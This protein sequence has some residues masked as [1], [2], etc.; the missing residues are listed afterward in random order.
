[1]SEINFQTQNLINGDN[2]IPGKTYFVES[3]I[4]EHG[5]KVKISGTFINYDRFNLM[6]FDNIKIHEITGITE[7]I[8]IYNDQFSTFY[9]NN[10]KELSENI[11]TKIT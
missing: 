6:T 1:M 9:E 2:L 3:E 4:P 11:E 8:K 7:K 5:I 10:E